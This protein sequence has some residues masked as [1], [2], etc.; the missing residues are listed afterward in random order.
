MAFTKQ[1]AP[2]A[3]SGFANKKPAAKQGNGNFTK[4]GSVTLSKKVSEAGLEGELRGYLEANNIAMW[5][6]FYLPKGVESMTVDNK[7]KLFLNFGP[8]DRS[9]V[10][11]PDFI[12]G[13]VSL[14]SDGE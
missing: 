9:K 5:V 4:V 3:K 2:A 7:T 12:V 6:G 14:V 1:S 11:V 13:Q 8:I 10:N